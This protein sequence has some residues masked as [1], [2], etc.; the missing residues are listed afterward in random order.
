MLE[1]LKAA[2]KHKQLLK[3]LENF[4]QAAEQ[5]LLNMFIFVV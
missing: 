5:Y 2:L 4:G 1:L 3:L